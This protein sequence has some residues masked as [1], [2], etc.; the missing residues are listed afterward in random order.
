MHSQGS[1]S[2][3]DWPPTPSARVTDPPLRL[4]IGEYAIEQEPAVLNT[5]GLGSCVAVAIYYPKE[6]IGGLI[7]AMLPYSEEINEETP[8]RFADTGTRRLV[9]TFL[10]ETRASKSELT[11]KIVGGSEM[12]SFA[13]VSENVGA[14][15]AQSA[16]E[17]LRSL[18]VTIE[19][20][21]IGG[22][23]GRSVSFDV[24]TGVVT[25]KTANKEVEKL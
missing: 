1:D 3:E 16:R 21:D 23:N 13:Q 14:R 6:S 9:E 11:A 5:Y 19:A 17:T 18:G 24:G 22:N 4:G 12:F 7:H 10:A 15:N 25:V 2:A 8:W 20:E